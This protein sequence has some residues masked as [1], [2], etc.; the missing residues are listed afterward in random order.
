MENKSELIY[1]MQPTCPYCRRASAYLEVL[2]RENPAYAKIPMRVV[3]ENRERALADAYD[4]WYV[5][6]FF[7]NGRKLHEG[8]ASQK[9]IQDVLDACLAQGA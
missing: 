1:F 7:L 4:Y 3:D 2:E 9:D 5:P 6:C 8:A